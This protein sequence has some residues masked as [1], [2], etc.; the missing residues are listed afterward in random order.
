VHDTA[1]PEPVLLEIGFHRAARL[2]THGQKP[3][4]TPAGGRLSQSSAVEALQRVGSEGNARPLH[5]DLERFRRFAEKAGL[6]VRLVV[7]TARETADRVRESWRNHEPLRA[8]PSWIRERI[9][10][11][12]AR[13]PL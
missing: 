5:A 12:M 8:V 10:A 9:E 7:R 3:G 11:H 6:P 1:D 2:G 4:I 13:V